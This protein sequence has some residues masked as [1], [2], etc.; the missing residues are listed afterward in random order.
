[1]TQ[2]IDHSYCDDCTYMQPYDHTNERGGGEYDVE[3]GHLTPG[4]CVYVLQRFSH[5]FTI[6]NL[7]RPKLLQKV[8]IRVICR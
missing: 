7:L 8:H 6:V 2:L 5:N 1:M 4:P 3:A